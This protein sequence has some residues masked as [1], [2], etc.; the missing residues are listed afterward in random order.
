MLSDVV[1]SNVARIKH[2]FLRFKCHL[3]EEP[4]VFV[5]PAER[6]SILQILVSPGIGPEISNVTSSVTTDLTDMYVV[7][8]DPRA[9]G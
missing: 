9:D 1:G 2:F 4:S 8:A 6:M 5:I 7:G 3:V